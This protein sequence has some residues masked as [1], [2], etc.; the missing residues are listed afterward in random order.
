MF[1]NYLKH[2]FAIFTVC[3]LLLNMAGCRVKEKPANMQ[4][5]KNNSDTVSD[6]EEGQKPQ[7][8]QSSKD[9]AFGSENKPLSSEVPELREDTSEKVEVT[10]EPES[11]LRVDANDSALG[12]EN[13]SSADNHGNTESAG[14]LW[15]SDGDGYYDIKIH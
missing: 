4:S 6:L 8:E 2:I 3:I 11:S 9:S 5:D 15:D 14:N 1:Y 7:D 10:I 13:S 12:T